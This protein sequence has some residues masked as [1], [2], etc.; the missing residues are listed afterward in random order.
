[1]PQIDY[2]SDSESDDES[3]D[4]PTTFSEKVMNTLNPTAVYDKTAG[5]LKTIKPILHVA[6][7]PIVLFLGSN[8]PPFPSL[9]D[10]ITPPI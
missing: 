7:I 4:T 3:L 8:E 10:L 9:F 2:S 6:W 5:V 1:M